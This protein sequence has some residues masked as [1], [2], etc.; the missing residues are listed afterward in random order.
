M[1]DLEFWAFF[2]GK[3]L[4]YNHTYTVAVKEIIIALPCKSNPDQTTLLGSTVKGFVAP[5][6]QINVV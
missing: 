3:L 2:G 6:T 4:S 5:S 1:M